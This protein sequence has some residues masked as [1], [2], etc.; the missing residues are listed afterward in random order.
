MR[1][2]APDPMVSC[3]RSCP[4]S[5]PSV[6][7]TGTATQQTDMVRASNSSPFPNVSLRWA[8]LGVRQPETST[9][10]AGDVHIWLV[11]V[12]VNREIVA[13]LGLWL[14][15]SEKERAKRFYFPRHRNE[16]IVSRGATRAV[17]ASY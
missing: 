6:W 10:V 12:D 9:L 16:F 8:S 5:A 17:L 2:S 4:G 14:A 15:G 11:P 7:R 1:R 13:E 3:E